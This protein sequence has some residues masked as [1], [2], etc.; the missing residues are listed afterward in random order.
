[1]RHPHPRCFA[2]RVWICLK[3]REIDFYEEPK[4]SEQYQN[5]GDRGKR[6]GTAR[7]YLKGRRIDQDEDFAAAM[8]EQE[9]ATV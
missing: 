5:K 7:N 1:M 6:P 9:F 2:Q 8:S 3:T 4:S